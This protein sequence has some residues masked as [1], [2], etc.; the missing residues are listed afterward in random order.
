MLI[1]DSRVSHP[2]SAYGAGYDMLAGRSWKILAFWQ[3]VLANFMIYVLQMWVTSNPY[4]IWGIAMEKYNLES[5]TGV[6]GI[7]WLPRPLAALITVL[8]APVRPHTISCSLVSLLLINTPIC[9]QA[10]LTTISV[11]PIIMDLVGCRSFPTIIASHLS[12]LNWNLF[13]F[14]LYLYARGSRWISW[15]MGHFGKR[16]VRQQTIH[17]FFQQCKHS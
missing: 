17:P 14:L 3:W 15:R 10:V 8:P 12:R 11:S 5:T 9:F 1:Y 13:L 2:S 6:T 4:T 7:C 16:L